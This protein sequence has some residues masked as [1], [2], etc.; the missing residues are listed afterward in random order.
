MNPT[1]IYWISTA[2]V[3]GFLL[4][5][6]ISYFASQSTIDGLRELGFPDFF[7]V[8][9]GVLQFLA[10]VVLLVPQVPTRVKEW[11]Y[12]G[13]ALFLL[14]ALVAHIAH[15]DSPAISVLLVVLFMALAIS[16]AYLARA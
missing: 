12:A 16:N 10:L 5:S 2:I 11:G 13:V 8:Q 15:R 6:G 14:T 7:R 4:L 1:L 9:L 3:A